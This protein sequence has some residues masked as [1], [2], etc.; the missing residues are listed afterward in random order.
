[1]IGFWALGY[2]VNPAAIVIAYGIASIAG[3]IV[4]T[5]GG[6]GAY[7]AIMRAFLGTAVLPASVV[8]A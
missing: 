5:P 2:S 6:A 8:I 7:E 3:F 4:I 1:M